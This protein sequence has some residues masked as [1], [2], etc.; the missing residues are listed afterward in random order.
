MIL[1]FAAASNLGEKN[2]AAKTAQVMRS[3]DF[4]QRPEDAETYQWFQESSSQETGLG[5]IRT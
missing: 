4:M 5:L 3:R 1:G 2:N